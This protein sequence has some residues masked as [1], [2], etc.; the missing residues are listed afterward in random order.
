M[1]RTLPWRLGEVAQVIIRPESVTSCRPAPL[2]SRAGRRIDSRSTSA[3][4]VLAYASIAGLEEPLSLCSLQK[5][6]AWQAA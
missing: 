5:S 3:T 1:S 2:P 4:S 6:P